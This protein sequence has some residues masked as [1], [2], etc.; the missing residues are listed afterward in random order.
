MMDCHILSVAHNATITGPK[1]RVCAAFTIEMRQSVGIEILIISFPQGLRAAPQ[2][3][4]EGDKCILSVPQRQTRV[5]VWF[6]H[7]S[8]NGFSKVNREQH[9][10]ERFV[11]L[12]AIWFICLLFT[13]GETGKHGTRVTSDSPIGDEMVRGWQQCEAALQH[14][15]VSKSI[16][17][18][19]ADCE[20]PAGAV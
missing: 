9:S 17:I 14:S 1:C 6:Q 2:L 4:K 7:Q 12:S 20:A 18:S 8:P 13:M 3:G 15:V 11:P 19:G 16:C 5:T 10:G